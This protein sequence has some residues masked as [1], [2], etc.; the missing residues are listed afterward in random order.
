M[1]KAKPPPGLNVGNAFFHRGRS[2]EDLIGAG[3]PA[4]VLREKR[5]AL[6]A[7]II[8]LCRGAALVQRSVGTR[9]TG[10]VCGQNGCERQHAAAADAAKEKGTGLLN[11]EYLTHGTETLKT[12]E[13]MQNEGNH[14]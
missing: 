8:E 4:A 6:I 14:K 2:D 5:D 9:H 11:A 7:Q 10:A 1:S 3:D 13:G 12:G